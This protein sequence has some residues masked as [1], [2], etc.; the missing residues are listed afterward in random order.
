LYVVLREASDGV[1][2]ADIETIPEDAVGR[3]K[4][5]YQHLHRKSLW[6]I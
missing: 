1:L 3:L 4:T 2:A 6:V 5:G